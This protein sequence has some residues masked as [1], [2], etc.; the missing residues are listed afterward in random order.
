MGIVANLICFPTIPRSALYVKCSSSLI[1]N[2]ETTS[3]HRKYTGWASLR[4][5]A[6]CLPLIH[7]APYETS[8]EFDFFYFHECYYPKNVLNRVIIMFQHKHNPCK[9]ELE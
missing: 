1:Q 6:E 5:P 2:P 4:R 3:A 8:S 9:L 7:F